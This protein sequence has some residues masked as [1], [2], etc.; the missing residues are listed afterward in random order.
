MRIKM[1]IDEILQ[2]IYVFA[3]SKDEGTYLQLK[4]EDVIKLSYYIDSLEDKEKILY[5][6]LGGRNEKESI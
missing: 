1:R 4:K 6:F 3:H 2:E 5:M